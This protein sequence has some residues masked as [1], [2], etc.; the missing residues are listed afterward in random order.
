[1]K[2]QSDSVVAVSGLE[3]WL[4]EGV[5]P[6]APGNGSRDTSEFALPGVADA[7]TTTQKAEE[8]G[9]VDLN[10]V[11]F[12]TLRNFGLTITEAAR[13]VSYRQRQGGR[14]NSLGEVDAI[15]GLSAD[16][17]GW[18]RAYGTLSR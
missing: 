15:V 4:P 16:L 3:E 7:G 5:V 10:S 1:M 11:S 2:H 13:F 6:R 17:R 12:E 9:A 18:L 14:L 8:R